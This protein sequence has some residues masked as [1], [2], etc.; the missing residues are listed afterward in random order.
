MS[1]V[2]RRSLRVIDG[3]ATPDPALR[4]LRPWPRSLGTAAAETP[5]PIYELIERSRQAEDKCTEA[6][7]RLCE[8]EEQCLAEHDSLKAM[9]PFFVLQKKTAGAAVENAIMAVLDLPVTTPDGL[10]AALAY[11]QG[12]VDGADE[13]LL[14]GRE[15]DFFIS[16][17]CAIDRLS[18]SGSLQVLS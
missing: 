4:P 1:N 12:I 16:L 10:L 8:A 2:T 9:S 7:R 15:S 6:N 13:Q 11:L 3:D 14:H 18:Q 17:A 5:D